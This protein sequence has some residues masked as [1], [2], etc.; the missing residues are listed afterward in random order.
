MKILDFGISKLTSLT[1]GAGSR[2]QTVTN[3]AA[4][5][6]S[7]LYMSP[8][9]MRASKNVDARTDIWSL[10][11]IL[12]ELVSGLPSF[13]ANTTA[14]LCALVLTAPPT[15]VVVAGTPGLDAVIARCL[16]KTPEKRYANVAELAAALERFGPPSVKTSVER[17]TRV[18][19]ARP[20][21]ASDASREQPAASVS[22]VPSGSSRN[23][24][25]LDRTEVSDS[26][27][28]KPP[29]AS[30]A[31]TIV[32]GAG[33]AA[34]WGGSSAAP[35]KSKMPLIAGG[36]AVA[37]LGV[38]A[39]VAFAVGGSHSPVPAHP[40]EPRAPEPTHAAALPT[41]RPATA[42]ATATVTATAAPTATAAATTP[43]RHPSTAPHTTAPK[44]AVTAKHA[45]TAAPI[46]T[47]G[48]GGRN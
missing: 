38:L 13:V 30:P 43:A 34:A 47:T 40:T 48:F 31:A 37:A 27:V 21:L 4:I 2:E 14:E 23:V 17:I 24:S 36:A 32:P 6:G 3:T 16:E 12:Q 15:P 46:D 8:E 42:T 1:A 22:I 28:T 44:P 19:G 5:V 41:D 29:V 33:T 9:Q 20:A 26:G 25:T 7:P 39:T 18:A 10:G 35:K 11:V 45:A